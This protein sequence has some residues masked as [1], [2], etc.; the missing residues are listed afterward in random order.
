MKL[1]I[2]TV[3]FLAAMAFATEAGAGIP[4]WCNGLGDTRINA[5]GTIKNT[6]E[7]EDPRNALSNLVA[8]ICRPEP[9]DKEHVDEFE[10]ARKKWSARLDLTDADWADVA[11]YATL[12]VRV[13]GEVD[14]LVRP[15][16]DASQA[17]RHAWSSFDALDQWAWIAR[18]MGESGSLTL[19]HNYL[20]DAL[21]AK[22]TEV[23]R[24]AYIRGCIQSRNPVQWAMCQGDI[25]RLDVKKLAAELRANKDYGGHEKTRVPIAVDDHKRL[26]VEHAAKVK[27]L[28]ASDAGYAKMFEA[29]QATR[30]E[31]EGRYQTDAASI[32][33]AAQMD[34]ARATH[35][36]KAFAG[37]EDKTWAA[38][39]TAVAT[40]PAK[41]YEGMHEDRANGKAFIDTAI[42]PITTN[43]KTYLASIA[44]VTCMTVGQEQAK[45]DV[46]IR[47]LGKE[48]Q[49]WPGFRGPRT[50]TESAILTAGITLDDREA[51]IEYPVQ[52]RPFGR[53][54]VDLSGGGEGVIAKLKPSGKTVTVEFKKQMV[55]Q[56]QCA[57][58]KR[59]NRVTQILSNGTLI[60][61]L[62][63]LRNETVTVN[64]AS[65]P[66]TVNARYLEGVQ[67]GMHVLV[68]EDV[69]TA[70]WAKPGAA[71]PTM[72]FGVPLK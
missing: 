11:E 7:D 65:D 34:D 30:K 20:V 37:C 52:S 56:V 31:W 3:S 53:H 35:S 41:K 33:L 18:D 2:G 19:D 72:V 26:L 23:G 57:E 38:W 70:V 62:I 4:A 12:G 54:D 47:M 51:K 60:Y 16:E 45:P 29:A 58:T 21:G 44:L 17:R 15:G 13:G 27:K 55:K 64:K 66:V 59:T 43:P 5:S 71:T 67:P 40:V 9:D 69:A 28:I 22:L 10:A 1:E 48:L 6:L 14:L 50:A 32:D 42:A 36:R 49:Y 63:C 8:R 39:K 61:E 24:L 25:D 68:T 46:L